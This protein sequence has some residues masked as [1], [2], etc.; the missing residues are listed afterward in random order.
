M[1]NPNTHTA[2]TFDTLPVAA[3][4]SP[5]AEEAMDADTNTSALSAQESDEWVEQA[6][7]DC[8]N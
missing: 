5:Q 3:F 6:L 1:S 4:A 2:L 7:F 8:Y